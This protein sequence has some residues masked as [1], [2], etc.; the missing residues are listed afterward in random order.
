[1]SLNPDLIRARCAEI[2]LL[3]SRL[4]EI[5]RLS[6]ETFLADQDTLDVACYRLFT[7]IE[8]PLAL[9]FHV[10]A[11]R[12]HRAP[13]GYA[14]CFRTLERAGLIPSNLSGRLQ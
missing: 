9:C 10:S 1:M 13:E 7:A 14:G 8:A 6:R 11:K 4:E 3:L 5:G 12:P 2:N